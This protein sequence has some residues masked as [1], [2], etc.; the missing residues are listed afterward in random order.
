MDNTQNCVVLYYWTYR[1]VD[2]NCAQTILSKMCCAKLQTHKQTATLHKTYSKMHHVVQSNTHEWTVTVCR[3][4]SKCIVSCYITQTCLCYA[5]LLPFIIVHTVAGKIWTTSSRTT[6]PTHNAHTLPYLKLHI[7]HH[8]V[9]T[10]LHCIRP[11]PWGSA[12]KRGLRQHDRG[13]VA[14]LLITYSPNM[15]L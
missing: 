13:R 15:C 3:M 7:Q 4:Y 2:C 12:S 10:M 6:L 14:A 9:P 1:R 8:S 11:W 5:G